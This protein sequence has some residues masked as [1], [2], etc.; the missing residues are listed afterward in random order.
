MSL[1]AALVPASLAVPAS[2]DIFQAGD[3][4]AQRAIVTA[5]WADPPVGPPPDAPMLR[6]IAGIAAVL[7]AREIRDLNR[8]AARQTR[9]DRQPQSTG[10]AW[11]VYLLRRPGDQASESDTVTIRR[12]AEGWPYA[13]SDG[14]LTRL[15]TAPFDRL[16]S[17]WGATRPDPEAFVQPWR[18]VGSDKPPETTAPRLIALTPEPSRILL[19]TDSLA[20][21]FARGR[22]NPFTGVLTRAIADESFML[23]YPRHATPPDSVTLAEPEHIPGVDQP[24]GLLVWINPTPAAAAPPAVL[25]AAARHG[26]AVVVPA[27]AGNDRPVIDRLQIA[28]DA[29]ATTQAVL[30]TDRERV[31]IAGMSGG[32]RLSSMLWAGAPDVFTGAIGVVGLNSHHPI[33]IGNGKVWPASHRIPAPPLAGEIRKHPIAA[34][35][36]PR[37]FNY[38]ESKSRIDALKRDGYTARLFDVPGLGHTMPDADILADAIAWIE[39]AVTERRDQAA[40]KGQRLLDQISPERRVELPAKIT[41]RERRLLERV[42]ILAPWTEP[43]W[44]AAGLLGYTTATEMPGTA[45]PVSPA[46]GAP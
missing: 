40:E 2:D 31:Y 8:A 15:A 25:T 28:L 22:S 24:V 19:D 5:S 35:S 7:N 43:A 12:T 29:V 45:K 44:E 21:R 14:T 32:G 38:T 41:L 42:T 9:I 26:L 18:V 36:G 33:P 20:D 17:G 30:W 46:P 37:D 1:A 4:P 3:R 11:T 23:T 13:E 16:S 6:E 39:R 10:D 27:N 34:I